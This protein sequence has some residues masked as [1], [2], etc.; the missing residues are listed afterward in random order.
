MVEKI[1]KENKTCRKV[2]YLGHSLGTLQMF[3]ALGRSKY[4]RPYFSQVTALAPCFIPGSNDFV[5]DLTPELYASL[6][7]VFEILDI[8]SLFGPNWLEQR[9]DMCNVL[10][11]DSEACAFLKSIP[12]GP[13]AGG[14]LYVYGSDIYGYSEIGVQQL[15][16]LGQ[17]AMTGRFQYYQEAYLLETELFGIRGKVVDV[18]RIT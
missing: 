1:V 7:G 3:Y 4:M 9:Q 13:V 17:V 2:S 8:E 18:S 11:N 5:K 10:E 16:H 14:E 6:A 12:Y 15:Q